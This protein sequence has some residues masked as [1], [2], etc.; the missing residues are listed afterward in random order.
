MI[1]WIDTFF[2]GVLLGGL[3]TMLAL[4]MVL[5]MIVSRYV[6][7]MH[8]LV[9]LVSAL[10]I[11]GLVQFLHFPVLLALL[12]ALVVLFW[13]GF[14]LHY[15]CFHRVQSSRSLLLA[16]FGV[17][18]LGEIILRARTPS[19][20]S[21]LPTGAWATY[22]IPIG[23]SLTIP[24][25]PLI[26]FIVSII[27]VIVMNR[28]LFTL[29][30]GLRL[31]AIADEPRVAHLLGVPVRNTVSIAIGVSFVL[32]GIG[33]FFLFASSLSLLPVANISTGGIDAISVFV[34]AIIG[35]EVMVIGGYRS[36]WR[37]LAG[38]IVMG[39]SQ[40]V[41]AQFG[42]E[43]QMLAGHVVFLVVLLARFDRLFFRFFTA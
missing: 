37:I 18:V 3:Y 5:V 39:V 11:V 35:F 36:L 13:L 12:L 9:V 7:V 29:P 38:G 26:G 17:A 32:A 43:W 20:P 25:M 2:Q 30:I 4:G 6:Q 10:G 23:E 15:F 34:F 22:S 16:S 28:F 8:G 40:S 27:M 42:Y 19:A 31:R 21:G 14:G 24:A 33:A 1:Q 41:G